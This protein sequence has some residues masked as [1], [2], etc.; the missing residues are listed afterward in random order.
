MLD[1]SGFGRTLPRLLNLERPSDFPV[2]AALFTHIEDHV[3]AGAFDRQKIRVSIHPRERD[4]WYWL[5]PFSNGRSSLGVVATRE[6][7]QRY[8]GSTSERLWQIVG[9]EP[10]LA[11]LLAQARPGGTGGRDRRLRRQRDQPC[12]V[13]GSH[14]SATP[15]SSSIRCSRPA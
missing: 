9:E 5:I 13:T 7:H 8:Q 14:C 15:R 12:T 3:E 6:F 4:V 10:S 2:R 11:Q 1:A